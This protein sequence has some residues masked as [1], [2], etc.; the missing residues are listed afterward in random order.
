MIGAARSG[1][2]SL[3]HHLS[4]HC[5]VFM[6]VKKE[7]QF[8]TSNFGKGVRWYE[9]L[10]SDYR[11]QAAVGE[12]SVSYTYPTFADQVV[13][14]IAST[15]GN[16]VRL[17]YVLR[18]PVERA[19][20]HYLYYRHY[21]A[22]EGS[23]TFE[24]AINKNP[25]YLGAS[26]Y[27]F[28]IEKYAA[29]FTRERLH[30]VLFEEYVNSPKKSLER[31][32]AFLNVEA[33]FMP[34]NLHL[35]TNMAFRPRSVQAQRA[36]GYLSR[37]RLR[38]FVERYLPETSRPILRNGIRKIMGDRNLPLLAANTRQRLEALFESE[39]I[40]LENYLRLDLSQWRADKSTVAPT[41]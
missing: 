29:M 2:T 3:Y 36:Y 17:V 21:T 1:T 22:M 40:W 18:N 19:F 24:E 23:Q 34:R 35:K 26:R 12:G 10:F 25:L 31:I 41:K 32:F 33:G 7:P 13:D 11:G 28:W 5:D 15:L 14:R 37:S 16:E 4:E 39:V 27:Q 8:F 6:P 30:I 38:M 20:S 9:D